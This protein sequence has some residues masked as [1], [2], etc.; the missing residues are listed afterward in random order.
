MKHIIVLLA[1]GWLLMKMGVSIFKGDDYEADYMPYTEHHDVVGGGF[2]GQDESRYGGDYTQH[3]YQAPRDE[4]RLYYRG[5]SS[6]TGRYV[7]R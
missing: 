2:Q 3:H 5:R 1:V 6:R 7:S 4:S